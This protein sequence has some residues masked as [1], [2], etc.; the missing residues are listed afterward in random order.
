MLGLVVVEFDEDVLLYE[1]GYIFGV[2]KVDW[3]IEFNDFVV[4]DYV[5]GDGFVVLFSWK[6][7]VCDDIVVIYGDK[8]NWWVVYV[9]WVF[10]F[11]GYEDVCFLDG[12]CDCWIV[13][14][15]E[16]ICEFVN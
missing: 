1:I 16:L 4:C 15:C 5:D 12:G 14:G 2:V 11:F 6:G 13:E 3:Y 10:F 7:I 9:L 8:N